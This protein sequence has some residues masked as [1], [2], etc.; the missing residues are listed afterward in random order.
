MASSRSCSPSTSSELDDLRKHTEYLKQQRQTKIHV[1]QQQQERQEQRAQRNAV[2]TK[3]SQWKAASARYYENHLEVR[4]KKCLKMAQKRCVCSG[5]PIYVYS[6]PLTPSAEKKLAR[7]RWDPPKKLRPEKTQACVILPDN[8]DAPC[9]QLTREEQQLGDFSTDID[10]D[11]SPRE[12]TAFG[13]RSLTHDELVELF[14]VEMSE[15]VQTREA[16][17][18]SEKY[19]F[20]YFFLTNTLAARSCRL[21]RQPPSCCSSSNTPSQAHSQQTYRHRMIQGPQRMTRRWS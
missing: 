6:I 7:R 12:P 1:Q 3:R 16:T 17:K 20:F 4:E 2:E 5:L 13:P 10:V 9:R 14:H 18:S 21:V 11:L 19:C 8:R 15:M